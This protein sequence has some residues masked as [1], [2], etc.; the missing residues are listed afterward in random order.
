VTRL[1]ISSVR[2]GRLAEVGA[3]GM[4]VDADVS[5]TLLSERSE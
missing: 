1:G 5:A 3:H 2:V 4:T